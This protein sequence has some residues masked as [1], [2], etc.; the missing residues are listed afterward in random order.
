MS[1]YELPGRG[2]V[3]TYSVVHDPPPGLETQKPYVVAIVEMDGGVRV[4][5]QIVDCDPKDVRIDMPV[6]VA[7][8]KLGEDG[9]AGIIHYGYKFRPTR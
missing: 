5:S 7:F 2:K 3:F 8:R 6:E 4:T 9:S 1:R